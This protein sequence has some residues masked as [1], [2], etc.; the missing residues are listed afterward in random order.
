[1]KKYCIMPFASVRIE[2]GKN[3]NSTQIRPCCLYTPPEKIV[4][5]SLDQYFN[6][7]M[8]RDL[9]Q[10]LLTQD[11]LPPGCI[12]C[13]KV[14]D[15]R[16]LS[17]RQQKNRYFS[18][19][20]L[21]KTDIQ[22]LDIFPSNL[23]NLTCVMCSPKFSSAVAAEQKNMGL[24][25]EVINFDETDRVC[26]AI[27]SLPNLKYITVAG[28]E[29][30]Y[31]KHCLRILKQIS[32]SEVENLK[33][34][35]N[36]TILNPLHVEILKNIPK[37]E[38]RFSIDGTEAYYEFIRYPAKWDA[39]KQNI[40]EYQQQL[41]NAKLEVVIVMQPLNIFSVF[42]WLAFANTNSLDTHWINIAGDSLGWSM[43]TPE[44]KNIISK[45]IVQGV[46]DNKI[47]SK[48]AITLLNYSK[49]VIPNSNFDP[50]YRNKSIQK[51]VLLCKHR[52][53]SLEPFKSIFKNLPSLQQDILFEFTELKFNQKLGNK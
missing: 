48:Q 18:V 40:L 34:T 49:N 6:S 22:E 35:T 27:K 15:A 30:F 16:H 2:D 7:D 11:T 32:A 37:L 42:D 8:L 36:G 20:N 51:I 24:I 10:H 23:C 13:K 39:V 41:P 4:F 25:N 14:E 38:L 50:E 45:F 26:D 28:G 29:F 47:T 43:L 12:A 5:D 33:I 46:R 21:N 53:L 3:K 9:Q 31:A 44:E 17:I 19:D 1:M 52:K